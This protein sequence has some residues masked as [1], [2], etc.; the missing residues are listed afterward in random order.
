MDADLRY[1]RSAMTTNPL[2][3]APAANTRTGA[4]L[5]NLGTPASASVSDVRRFLR[6][7]LSDPRVI[8]IPPVLRWLLL[9]CVILPFRPRKTAAAYAKIWTAQGSPLL[10]HSRALAAAVADALGPS[11]LVG[12]GMRYGEPTIASALAQLLDAKV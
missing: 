12:L 2:H 3:T 5:L 4:L 1:S 7:F 11:W 9:R 10:V 8:D 6:E